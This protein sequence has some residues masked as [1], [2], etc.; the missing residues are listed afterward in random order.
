MASRKTHFQFTNLD[1]DHVESYF[2]GP[3]FS[4][5]ALTWN[6]ASLDCRHFVHNLPLNA[7]KK[8]WNRMH[9]VNNTT[10]W[11]HRCIWQRE[12][13]LL[14]EAQEQCINRHWIHSEEYTRNE[15]RAKHD[16]HHRHLY[17]VQFVQIFLAGEIDI[18]DRSHANGDQYFG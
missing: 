12:T 10:E 14:T 13:K 18:S 4:S 7:I 16:N 6:T 3:E 2:S 15:I 8:E 5:V 9:K 1:T 17:V 11:M